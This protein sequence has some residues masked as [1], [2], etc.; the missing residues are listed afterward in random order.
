MMELPPG[1]VS[2][3]VF[4]SRCSTAVNL[5][6]RVGASAAG[7]VG[8]CQSSV[9][10]MPSPIAPGKGLPTVGARERPSDDKACCMQADRR[11]AP[12]LWEEAVDSQADSIQAPCPS[13]IYHAPCL[14]PGLSMAT[15]GRGATALYGIVSLPIH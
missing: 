2:N 11:G 15:V 4:L 13:P 10:C 14:H 8:V 5:H 6:P 9:E 7:L 12:H 1:S 3:S